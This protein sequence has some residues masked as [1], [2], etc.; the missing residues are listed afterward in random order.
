LKSLVLL[1]QLSNVPFQFL[2][3]F[4]VRFS[5][6]LEK[7]H[8]GIKL[9]HENSSVTHGKPQTNN[10]AKKSMISREN[11]VQQVDPPKIDIKHKRFQQEQARR[12][13]RAQHRAAKQTC[14]RYRRKNEPNAIFLA[15]SNSR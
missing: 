4:V 5:L 8:H 11:K 12:L 10:K 1:H 6:C 7:A 3:D 15:I 14:S 9:K 2:Y 13:K